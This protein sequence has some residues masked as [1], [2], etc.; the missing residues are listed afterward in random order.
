LVGAI[1][2]SMVLH[3]IILYRPFFTVSSSSYSHPDV[4]YYLFDVGY[5]PDYT[6][7]LGG[8]AG[9]RVDGVLLL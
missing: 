6:V 7:E 8:M 9:C 4:T 5:I 1:T 2:L 3:F